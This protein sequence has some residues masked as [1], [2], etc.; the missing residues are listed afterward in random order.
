MKKPI[1]EYENGHATCIAEDNMG[2]KFIG[3]AWCAPEDEDMKS[4]LVGCTIAE[5]RAQIAAATAY[6][7]DLKIKLAALK[8]LFYS[9]KH[10]TKYNPKSYE[11]SMMWRQINLTKNDLEIAKH[12][13]AVLKLDLFEYINDKEAFYKAIRKKREKNLT[14]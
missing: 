14:N 3:E 2:R 12:Q 8:Q 5:Y 6:R 11:A 4:E 7:N 10:S 13:L 9:M 1:F